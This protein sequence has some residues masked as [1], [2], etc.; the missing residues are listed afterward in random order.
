MARV[1][2]TKRKVTIGDRTYPV[3]RANIAVLVKDTFVQATTDQLRVAAE[4]TRELILDRLFAASPQRPAQ[5]VVSRPSPLRP[6]PPR[7]TF[8]IGPMMPERGPLRH[9]HLRRFYVRRKAR[10]QEDGRKLIATGLLVNGL[11]VFKGEQAGIPYYIV[12]PLPEEVHTHRRPSDSAPRSPISFR[13]LWKVHEFGSARARVPARPTWGPVAEQIA[14]AINNSRY[15]QRL[16]ADALRR[17][18][19]RIA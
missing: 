2:R 17:S 4:E 11:E 18:L 15:R 1:R 9:R 3:S 5:A 19:R 10:R 12:R 14:A 8:D 6:G 13:K 16:K 7:R